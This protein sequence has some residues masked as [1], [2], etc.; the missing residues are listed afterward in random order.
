M[1]HRGSGKARS[2]FYLINTSLPEV[3]I[4]ARISSRITR[5]LRQGRC[6]AII[7]TGRHPGNQLTIVQ[8][9]IPCHCV[10]STLR[11]GDLPHTVLPHGAGRLYLKPGHVGDPPPFS[12]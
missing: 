6:A 3:G 1:I 10:L 7:V 9:L 2:A 11:Y 8:L 5:L 12:L 4:C